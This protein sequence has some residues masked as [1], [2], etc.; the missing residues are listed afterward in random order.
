[1]ST[2]DTAPKI[3]DFRPIYTLKDRLIDY[4]RSEPERM[5]EM[6]SGDIEKQ[7]FIICDFL[8]QQDWNYL[9]EP[10]LSERDK[11]DIIDF[12]IYMSQHFKL[13]YIM[14]YWEQKYR[15]PCIVLNVGLTILETA[16]EG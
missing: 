15:R 11:E 4:I 6:K 9:S 5:N 14:H 10:S 7:S 16:S 8:A 13:P 3:I 1:M 2:K 12:C